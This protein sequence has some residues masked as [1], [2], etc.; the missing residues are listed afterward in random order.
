MKKISLILIGILLFSNISFAE[1]FDNIQELT[2]EQKAQLTRIINTYKI[3]DSELESRINNYTNKIQEILADS[4][5]TEEQRALLQ[6]A[7][8][9]NITTL[10]ARRQALEK[11]KD[12][13]YKSIL[14]PEQ[15]NQVL[16]I[17]IQEV[18]N[19]ILKNKEN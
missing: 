6:G 13:M 18:L 5:K 2:P 16:Q 14:S 3:Q 8:E 7:Y 19:D 4:D 9:R 1:N 10:K 12:D 15:Y 11:E 17:D